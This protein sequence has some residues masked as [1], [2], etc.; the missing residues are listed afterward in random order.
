[1]AANIAKP[2]CDEAAI[3]AASSGESSAVGGGWHAT[4]TDVQWVI[5]SYALLL[6]AL[7]LTADLWATSI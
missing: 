4:I 5:E 2:P 7:L 1:L 3:L 6:S